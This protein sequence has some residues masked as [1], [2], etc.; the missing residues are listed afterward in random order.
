MPVKF[1]QQNNRGTESGEGSLVLPL[2]HL[3]ILKESLLQQV[4]LQHEKDLDQH[5]VL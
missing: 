1:K 2:H 3:L 4:Y 5:V